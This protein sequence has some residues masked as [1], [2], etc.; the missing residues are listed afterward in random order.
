MGRPSNAASKQIRRWSIA[1]SS[2]RSMGGAVIVAALLVTACGNSANEAGPKTA[3]VGTSV[4]A[5]SS[6]AAPATT[7]P[8][9]ATTASRAGADGKLTMS[10]ILPS[11]IQIEAA[12]SA[13]RVGEDTSVGIGRGSGFIISEDGLA[14]TNNH[15]VMGASYIEVYVG[16]ETEARPAKI[17]GESECD[18]LAVIDID[19]G[20]FTPMAWSDLEP[21]PGVEVFAAGFP[22]GDPEP[23][24]TK[25]VV[26]KAEADGDR[27]WASIASTIEHDAN[28]QPG[29]SGGP[30]LT[31]DGEVIGINY[32]GGDTRD[33]G[34]NQF[35]AIKSSLAEPVVE[36]LKNGDQLAIGIAPSAF[37]TD[38]GVAGI[39]VEAVNDGSP[40]SKAGLKSGDIITTFRGLPVGASGSMGNF[41]RVLRSAN[42]DEAVSIE[43]VRLDTGELF[44][45]EIWGKPLQVVGLLEQADSPETDPPADDEEQLI[46]D[47]AGTFAFYAPAGWKSY[48]TESDVGFGYAPTVFVSPDAAASSEETDDQRRPGVAVHLVDIAAG[49]GSPD[50]LND[51]FY[52][53]WLDANV[54]DFQSCEASER[55]SNRGPS[56]IS[57]LAQMLNCNDGLVTNAV[58]FIGA[59]PGDTKVVVVIAQSNV[60]SMVLVDNILATLA[61]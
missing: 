3:S 43:A 44:E 36:K 20:G 19:G 48:E 37:E 42:E 29:N 38:S 23:T 56:D 33:T 47:A 45:G 9:P 8:P 58:W 61:Y 53:Q 13:R 17:L 25:G 49:G 30:L 50:D 18:D 2:R 11:L 31:S 5:V 52:G 6:T 24:L 54:K 1:N 32:S 60:D 16:G 7:T 28:I 46:T 22:L 39:W 4:V 26:S 35:W 59:K 51:E 27:W 41:C 55:G 40:A 12:G 34:T 21:E 14:V 10:D 15:V 57:G